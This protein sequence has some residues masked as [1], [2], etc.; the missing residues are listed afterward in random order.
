[1]E[2]AGDLVVTLKAL[3]SGRDVDYPGYILF[4]TPGKWKVSV[5]QGDQLLASA[6]FLVGDHANSSGLQLGLMRSAP[7][8]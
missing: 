7:F 3:G 5:A 8:H 4:T 6:V 1:M 2:T